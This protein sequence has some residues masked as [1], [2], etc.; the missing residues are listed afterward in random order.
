MAGVMLLSALFIN[1]ATAGTDEDFM[2]ARKAFQAGNLTR[3]SELTTRLQDHSLAPYAAYYQLRMQLGKNDLDISQIRKFLTDYD[4]TLVADKLRGEWLRILGKKRQWEPFVTEYPLLVNTDPELV[5]YALQQ[6]H[7]SG[8]SQALREAKALWSGGTDLPES[9]RPLFTALIDSS[10]LDEEAIWSKLRQALEA[11]NLTLAKRAG[12]YLPA[13]QALNPHKL[14]AASANPLRYLEKNRHD[15]LTRADRETALFAVTRLTRTS[16]DQMLAYWS[17][18]HDNFPE[19]D[20][21]FFMAQLAEQAARKHDPRALEWF[22]QS[23]SSSQPV[24]LSDTRLMWKVRAALR[25]GEWETVLTSINTLSAPEQQTA[26]WRYWKARALMHKGNT[27][28]AR[29]LFSTLTGEHHFYGQ[30]AREELGLTTDIPT[31][32]YQLDADTVS[33][34][35]Q[36]PGIDRM[37]ALNRMGLRTEA[38]NEW[39]WTLRGFNDAQLLTASA[40]A[41][42]HHIYDRSINTAD[43][44]LQHH[45][46]TLRYPIPHRD[47]LQ[48]ITRQN[49]LDEAWVYGLIRQESRFIAEA[50][51]PAGAI[52]LMQIMPATARWTGKKMGLPGYRKLPVGEIDTNLRLGSYYLKYVLSQLDNQPLLASAAYNAGPSRAAA[53]RDARPLEGAIYAETIP[54]PET[55]EYVKKVLGNAMYYA[56]ILGHPVRSL[57]ERLGMVPAKSEYPA[58]TGQIP[59]ADSPE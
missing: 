15:I 59:A 11:G 9:C 51:S 49:E 8:D 50:R 42:Q 32:P 46:F 47:S 27:D 41:R 53:W 1:T 20:Q 17:R 58:S 57:K 54:F 33:A 56:R 19:S 38:M 35:R 40:I 30:L 36:L 45:D 10:Q 18:I 6:R 43:R 14:D 21:S 5:C 55:R 7:A 23:A 34:V 44:T 26:T 31:E 2:A 29:T 22:R 39:I 25:A 24:S 52:G 28:E 13:H 48:D 12:Q 16:L 4:G 37:L 3:V